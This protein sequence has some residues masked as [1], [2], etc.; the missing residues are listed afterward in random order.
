MTLLR[1][2]L[3]KIVWSLLMVGG[4]ASASSPAVMS[5]S[6]AGIGSAD[7]ATVNPGLPMPDTAAC[8]VDLLQAERFGEHGNNK[9]MDA[10]P[11]RFA[12]RPP[13]KCEGP[14]AKIVLNVKFAVDAGVQYDRTASIWLNGVNLYFGTTQ[15][16]TKETAQTWQVQRDLT[17]YAS[18]FQ[19][20][21]NGVALLNNFVDESHNSVITV[22][23]KL[24]FYPADA[25]TKA[26]KAADLVI[27]LD[28]KG[29]GPINVQTAAD[30]A[31]RDVTFPRSTSR[32]YMDVL[33]QSQFKD[34]FWYLC[35][36]EK[37]VEQTSAFAMRRGYIGAPK[38]PRT[39]DGGNFREVEVL[40]DGAPAGL[41][42][43]SPWIYTGGINPLLWRPIT[44]V[45]TLNFMPYRLDLTPFAGVL[46]DGRPH[47]VAVKVLGAN[48]YFAVVANLLVFK[49]AN[50]KQVR[51]AV[52]RNTL[53][54]TVITPAVTSTLVGDAAV[55]N[56]DV[57]TSASQQ[58]V[59]EGYVEGSE[60]RVI[61][62]VNGDLTFADKQSFTSIGPDAHRKVTSLAITATAAT[63]RTEPNRDPMEFKRMVSYL[64]TVDKIEHETKSHGKNSSI[65][66]SQSFDVKNERWSAGQM[67][68]H[69]DMTDAVD[70]S[71][72]MEVTP[73][74]AGGFG[75]FANKNQAGSQYFVYAD[76]AGSCY[77]A[78]VWALQGRV[79][80][81]GRADCG[82]TPM[83]WS[84]RPDGSPVLP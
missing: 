55:A 81:I 34:E 54:D 48:H 56:G 72:E 46:A 61:T 37:Y 73:N 44:A 69:D 77:R 38:T 82:A 53:A 60:G 47:K 67:V 4:A 65:R 5:T 33:A 26:Q 21:G 83:R 42:P 6:D 3:P 36:P 13:G 8:V 68:W 40:I 25:T 14:F 9:R 31:G 7:V 15:E 22:D 49:D 32:V 75:S 18:L 17:E 51:G 66:L 79:T 70:S 63:V 11:H 57:H 27:A 39:C 84:A 43:V 59:I 62:R 50:G 30:E 76:S 78:E 16:P 41:A 19:S 28:P 45:Q 80:K 64:T 12:Y 35:L 23:A 29:E 1:S 20:P 52:T 74:P 10:T 58:Y 24:L 71:T 2:V